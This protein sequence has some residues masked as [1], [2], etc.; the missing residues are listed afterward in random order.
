MRMSIAPD[1]VTHADVEAAARTISGHVRDTPLLPAG[2][3]GRR[4]GARVLLKAENLQLTGSFKARGATNMIRRLSADQLA[5]GVVAASAGNH[6][7]AVAFAARDAGAHAV[8]IMP[9]HAPRAKVA[10]VQQ[11]GGEVRL[12]DGA[13]DEAGAVARR[14]AEEQGMTLVHAFDQPPVVAGQATIGLEIA[15][16]APDT[17]LIVVPLGGGGL[18]AGV[19]LA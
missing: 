17:G 3:L 8:L 14:F 9:E 4:V 5:A 13:Y 19:A 7:Q 2:E 6:A 10:A 18:A 11:Y 16:D 15:R 12:I 1:T